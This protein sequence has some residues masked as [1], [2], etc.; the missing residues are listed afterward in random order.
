VAS[1]GRLAAHQTA[2]G[3]LL[4]TPIYMSPEQCRGTGHLDRRSDIYAL[5]CVAFEILTGRPPFVCAGAGEFIVAHLTEP[6]PPV[7]SLD[8]RVPE[9]MAALVARM[10][11]KD[12]G[13]RPQNMSE[14]I[15]ALMELVSSS[16]A[17]FAGWTRQATPPETRPPVTVVLPA[18]PTP[19][20]PVPAPPPPQTTFG[21]SA[22]EVRLPTLRTGGNPAVK[23]LAIA[24]AGVVV[25]GLLGYALL[26]SSSDRPRPEPLPRDPEP[27]LVVQGA[28]DVAG[29][30]A[31]APAPRRIVP[32]ELASNP[33]GAEVWIADEPERRGH[34]PLPVATGDLP[35]VVRLRSP[36]YVERTLSLTAADAPR[37]V[38]TLEKLVARKPRKPTPARPKGYIKLE[39]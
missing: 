28:P 30:P 22:S 10:L 7:R 2:G 23:R 18:V 38:V 5:G 3:A 12:P 34:T 35:V 20:P 4:G 19:A 15:R 25:I 16:Q 29:E 31:P 39:D 24:A 27:P 1:D 11:A 32:V 37:V 33:P 17:G 13:E 21:H 6:P 8:A 9:P 14:V 36:G 26:F